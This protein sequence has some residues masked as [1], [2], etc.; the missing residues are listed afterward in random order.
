MSWNHQSHE[1]N[2]Q[3]ARAAHRTQRSRRAWRVF[4]LAC[5][6]LPLMPGTA[7]AQLV[8]I[9]NAKIYTVSGPIIERGTIVLRDGTI[10][11]VGASVAVPAGATV[12][13]ATGKVVTPGFLDSATG[14]GV[15]EVG[16]VGGSN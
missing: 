1:K 2:A 12:I 16:A 13:D 8:A 6:A 10:A 14:I 3:H 4:A 11:A 7:H 5:T 9:T 15:T